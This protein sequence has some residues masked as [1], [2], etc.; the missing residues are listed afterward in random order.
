MTYSVLTIAD[1]ILKI[2][3]GRDVQLTPLQLMKLVYIA[4]GFNLAIRGSDLF[5][6]RIE[7]WQYGPVIPDLYQATKSFGRDPIP[8]H[9]ISDGP[10]AVDKST[11]E[12]LEDVFSKYGHLSGFA[13]S[14]LTH[15]T[16]TPWAGVYEDGFLNVE[17]PDQLIKEHYERIV[18]GG[19]R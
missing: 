12:F 9:R 3:K 18:R 11:H 5:G 14:S 10:I 19:H 13:L 8:L 7:A 4:H 6:E 15:Q 17:I 2:A 16:G 1:A